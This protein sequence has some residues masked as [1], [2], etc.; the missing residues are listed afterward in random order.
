MFSSSTSTP[1]WIPDD[2]Q[3]KMFDGDKNSSTVVKIYCV[4]KLN[5]ISNSINSIFNSI[6]F[7]STVNVPVPV[8]LLLFFKN[9]PKKKI[10]KKN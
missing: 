1:T 5:A 2:E 7:N 3:R 6:Q 4:H 10:K 9:L 8:L